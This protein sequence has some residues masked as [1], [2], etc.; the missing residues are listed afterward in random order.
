MKRRKY[1]NLPPRQR[2]I[3]QKVRNLCRTEFKAWRTEQSYVG[4]VCRFRNWWADLTTEQ[5]ANTS[6]PT[7]K[8]KAFLEHLAVVRK[9]SAATQSQA[10]NALLFLFRVMDVPP[11]D[12]KGIKRPPE[13]KR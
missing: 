11:G 4:W 12:L 3:V 10:Y 8:F 6:T 13:R 5:K 1:I 7:L 2:D 9:I